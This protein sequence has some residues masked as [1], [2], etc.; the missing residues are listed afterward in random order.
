MIYSHAMS[1]TPKLTVLTDPIPCGRHFFTEMAKSLGRPVKNILRPLPPFVKNQKYRGHFAVTRS[2]VEG[3]K[4]IGAYFN[5]NPKRLRD[6]GEVVAVL[7]GV[8]TLRQTI[9]W[10]KQGRIRKLL[11]G[12]NILVWPSEHPEIAAPEVDVC[13]T[14]CDWTNEGY[15]LDLPSLRGRCRAWPAGVNTNK[16]KPSD[17]DIE[18]RKGITVFVK[19]VFDG[20]NLPKEYLECL[21][22]SGFYENNTH[23]I[24][25]GNDRTYTPNEYYR[26]LAQSKLMIGFSMSESQ[27]IAW[28]EAWSMDVPTLICHNEENVILGKVTRVSTAPYLAPENGRFFDNV[29]DLGL[30]LKNINEEKI[31]FS[32]RRWVLENMSDEV[33]AYK[34]LT[35]AYGSIHP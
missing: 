1:S 10:K 21:H 16:W 3:L 12:P 24:F 6:V 23:F 7:S 5:Y 19:G 2:L 33:C 22:E 4:Q 32:P 35:L 25:R 9:Q 13:I 27:G 31:Q 20:L 15:E 34:L 26:K 8:G 14:P 18:T 11:A 29:E 30:L 17:V 28:A